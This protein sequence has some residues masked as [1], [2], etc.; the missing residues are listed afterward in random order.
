MKRL[1]L[2]LVLAVFA[3]MRPQAQ[4]ASADTTPKIGDEDRRLF[5]II[6]VR[7]SGL[8]FAMTTLQRELDATNAELSRLVQRLQQ[9]HPEYD[10]LAN[11]DGSLTY[12]K[13]TP[14]KR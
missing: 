2:I 1:V 9:A 14:A 12:A 3:C 10:V 13:K 7:A 4:Q 11:P 8:Q 5:T 6:Q